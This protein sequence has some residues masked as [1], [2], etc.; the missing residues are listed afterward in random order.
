M[1]DV[2]L[3]TKREAITAKLESLRMSP[4][5]AELVTQADQA[6]RSFKAETAELEEQIADLD[7]QIG[8]TE[9]SKRADAERGR[10]ERWFAQRQALLAEHEVLLQAIADS[11]AATRALVDAIDRTLAS[12]ARMAVLAREL[13]TSGKVPMALSGTDLVSRLAGRIASVMATIRGHRNRFGALVWAG[14]GSTLYPV[15]VNWRQAEEKL[16]A[17]AI[18]PIIERSN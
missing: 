10:E 5:V 14:A 11:E 17:A 9:R 16:V 13:S 4:D 2:E 3:E 15:H 12:N 1:A 7:R 6:V 18:Q 8:A